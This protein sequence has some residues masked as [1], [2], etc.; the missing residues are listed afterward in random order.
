MAERRPKEGKLNEIVIDTL[1]HLDEQGFNDRE[2]ISILLETIQ[3]KYG[4]RKKKLR[5]VM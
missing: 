4:F 2:K 1:N 5:K 3:E